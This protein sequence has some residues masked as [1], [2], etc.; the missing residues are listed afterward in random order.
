METRIRA[1]LTGPIAPFGPRDEP[2]G[3]YK[4][5]RT[6]QVEVTLLGLAGEPASWH[7][8]D[9]ERRPR[10]RRQMTPKA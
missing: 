9:L 4:A 2:S 7:V 8:A 6:G 5:V 1:V 10:C 3:Y